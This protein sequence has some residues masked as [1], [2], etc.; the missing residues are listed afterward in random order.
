MWGNP[1]LLNLVAGALVGMA[2]LG[3]S[4]AGLLTLLRSEA[5]PLRTIVLAGEASHLTQE[6]VAAAVRPRRAVPTRRGQ[7][8]KASA[9]FRGS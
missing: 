1:R 4:V 7:P 5:F 3:F 2:L 6:Q 8:E 9:A